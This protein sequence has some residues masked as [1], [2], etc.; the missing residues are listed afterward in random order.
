MDF[1]VTFVEANVSSSV[2]K[3]LLYGKIVL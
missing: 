3:A 1:I 2:L